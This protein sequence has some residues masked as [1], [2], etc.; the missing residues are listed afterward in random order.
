MP[1]E[2]INKLL[3]QVPQWYLEEGKLV[4][5][6]KFKNFIEALAFINKVGQIAQSE[7][8]HPDILLHA[9]NNVKLMLYTHKINGLH[10]NDFI[11]ASKIDVLHS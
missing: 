1:Q 6:F 5:N 2:E 11:L 7:G 8:H 10:Q 9:W 4:R 3:P